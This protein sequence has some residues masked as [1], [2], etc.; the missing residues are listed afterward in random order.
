MKHMRQFNL[1][2]EPWVAVVGMDGAHEE[3][4]LRDTLLK[5]PKIRS[6]DG[7]L[8]IQDAAMLRFLLAFLYR[9][10]EPDM[11]AWSDLWQAKAFP[12]DRVDKY[13]NGP[14]RE[15]SW[16]DGSVDSVHDRL[17]LDADDLPFLQV[18]GM[19]PMSGH[20]QSPS[21]IMQDVR[22]FGMQHVGTF[23]TV[24][25]E[26]SFSRISPGEAARWLLSTL[27]YDDAAQR[28]AMKGDP[29]LAISRGKPKSSVYPALNPP[30]SKSMVNVVGSSLFSTLMLNLVPYDAE[31]MLI[32]AN[33]GIPLWEKKPLDPCS[34][35]RI[36]ETG[37]LERT[38]ATSVIDEYVF[39]SRKIRL[40]FDD[41]GMVTGVL[42]GAG[43]RMM[44]PGQNVEPMLA[45]RSNDT[46]KGGESIVPVSVGVSS[47]IW[48]ALP[49]FMLKSGDNDMRPAVV[50]FAD[51]LAAW[52][53]YGVGEAE[54]LDLSVSTVQYGTQYACIS[55]IRTSSMQLPM[56]LLKSQT[57]CEL[58]A[59]CGSMA[60]KAVGLWTAF[61]K[62]LS[63]AL[64]S[65]DGAV[66]EHLKTEFIGILE[67]DFNEWLAGMGDDHADTERLRSQWLKTLGRRAV[68]QAETLSA[69]LPASAF[70]GNDDGSGKTESYGTAYDSL[71]RGLR[72]EGML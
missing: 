21:A 8:G 48:R 45:W 52:P 65:T 62:R 70:A 18:A 29:N 72:R 13:V 17:F 54:R 35:R 63:V 40:L 23:M 1:Y 53:E 25:Q 37:E 22:L 59:E 68:S 6:L 50:R 55:D 5:A 9:V 58:A 7:E 64:G 32:S 30:A 24:R 42:L 12:M 3:L 60:D 56:A 61:M 33:H 31:G 10:F 57:L 20:A 14:L 2:D 49:A 15:D 43:L 51:D 47:S 36:P 19:E 71:I 39:P 41:E 28:G 66:S 27:L 26:S 67:T 34:A 69:T 38:A 46:G 44:P 16:T 11:D 4:S